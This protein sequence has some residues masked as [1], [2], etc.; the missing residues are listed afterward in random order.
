M[1]K[2]KM[3]YVFVLQHVGYVFG[4]FPPSL[5]L[6]SSVVREWN[7]SI[8]HCTTVVAVMRM[9]NQQLIFSVCLLL[10]DSYKRE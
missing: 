1:K 7:T 10:A 3:I 4:I 6:Q 9:S 2:P 8:C 5:L